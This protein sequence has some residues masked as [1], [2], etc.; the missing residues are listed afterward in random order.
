MLVINTLGKF[1]ISN[2]DVVLDEHKMHSQML[3]KLFIYLI[4]HRGK[5]LSS[6]EIASAV[7]LGDEVDNPAGALKNLMYRLRKLLNDAFGQQE[8]ILTNRGA[9][10]WNPEME[11]LV[12]AEEFEKLV[13]IAKEQNDLKIACDKYE[14]ALVI[15]EGGFLNSITD[16]HW[17]QNLN[18]YYHSLYLTAARALAELLLKQKK[19]EKV[20]RICGRALEMEPADEQ[21]YAY[22]IRAYMYSGKL[23]QAME[24]YEIAQ[25]SMQQILGISNLIILEEV[26]Q[27]LLSMNNGTKIDNIDEIQSD[28]MEENPEGVFFCGYQVFKEIYQLEARK[29]V[30][31]GLP[32]QLILFTIESI[33]NE[34][35]GV[36]NFRIKQ[37]IE[38]LETVMKYAL[39]IGDVAAKYSDSQYVLLVLNCS[40]ESGYLVANRIVNKMN[41]GSQKYNGIKIKIDVEEVTCEKK[42]E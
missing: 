39:R 36:R 33:N 11:V 42:F 32:N 22:K 24:F 26:Y 37:G 18:T 19:Y 10:S 5:D 3:I 17:V 7:W 16:L 20:E 1:R 6:E 8:Y 9:Y 35:E 29:S 23:K 25:K 28:V 27:E 21:L 15:Y 34:T 12:D 13:R 30:R 2:G 41:D 14:K 40:H 4:V 38:K 31:S